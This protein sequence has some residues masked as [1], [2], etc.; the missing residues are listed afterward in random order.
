MWLVFIEWCY[1]PVFR[2]DVLPAADYFPL[3]VDRGNTRDEVVPTS[4]QIPLTT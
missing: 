3:V 1:L 2:V 4:T